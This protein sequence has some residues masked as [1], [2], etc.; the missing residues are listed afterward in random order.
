MVVLFVI[1]T[2]YPKQMKYS[3]THWSTVLPGRGT[4]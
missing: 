3:I 2:S 4:I 1:L